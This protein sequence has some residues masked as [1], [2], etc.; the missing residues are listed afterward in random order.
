M[1]SEKY[2]VVVVGGGAAGMMAAYT[3][4]KR[5]KRVIVLERNKVLGKKLSITGGGRCNILNAEFDVK[6]L[7]SHYGEAGK[8]LFSPFS[9]HSA[10]DS[11][12][13]FTAHDLPLVV[14]ARKRAFPKAMSAPLV[15][16]FFVKLLNKQHVTLK[17][18]V[19]ITDIVLSND[20][21]KIDLLI[22]SKGVE[23]RS[24]TFIFAAGG[25]SY[26]E[27]GSDGS[28][29]SIF[30][31]HNYTVHPANP[32]I[33]PLVT[34]DEWMHAL[35]GTTV[36]FCKIT[37]AAKKPKWTQNKPGKF[38][39]T[40]KVLFTH[41]GISGPPVLNV[42]YKV[43]ELL[44]SG[45]VVSSIDFFPDTDISIL[46]K[47]V[48]QVFD[49]NKNKQFKNIIS[50][51]APKGIDKAFSYHLEDEWLEKRVC[52]IS[53]E[54]RLHFVTLLKAMP[55]TVTGTMGLDWAVI[56][57]GGIDLKD[58]DTRT[59]QSRLHS[60][61]YFVGDMLHVNRPSGGYSLQLCWTTGFVAGS[62]V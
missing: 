54:E 11:W 33:V 17:K 58:I 52:D 50:L 31:N 49:N 36:S 10:Q 9:K 2:D 24:E 60:N 57:D 25:S 53:K 19:K 26:P 51:I 35:S 40:G 29:F 45:D 62:S 30:Q 18:Q 22:D 13:F 21:K 14:E 37:F 46:R 12:N 55:F 8:F 20:Q 7:L 61:A 23:Y 38:S 44:Q 3:A 34:K 47:R 59:M 32:N 39:L 28:L 4:A 41:F 6:R 16:D 43:K 56:S 1:R 48:L 5:G 15:T 27:T 42:A